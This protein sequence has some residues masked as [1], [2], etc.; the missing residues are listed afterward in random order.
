MPSYTPGLDYIIATLDALLVKLR[1][2][3]ETTDEALIGVSVGSPEGV[4]IGSPGDLR[5]AIPG[6][7]GAP[8]GLWQKQ[9]GELTVDGWVEISG[10]SGALSQHFVV[11]QA[12]DVSLTNA[13]VLTA[14]TNITIDLTVPGQVIINAVA[15]GG[16]T[17]LQT[18][19]TNQGAV[20]TTQAFSTRIQF[21][22]GFGWEFEDQTGN[23]VVTISSD[24]LA[25][26]FTAQG[27]NTAAG[28]GQAITLTGGTA[29]VATQAGG[30]I[31]LTGGTGN[32]TGTGGNLN[33]FAGPGGATG[34]GGQ[35]TILGGA[36]GATSGNGGA[37]VMQGGLP[38]DGNG[39]DVTIAGRNAATTTASNRD[40]GDV[41]ILGGLATLA[42]VGGNIA[43]VA[44]G[45]GATGTA[46]SLALTGGAA[47]TGS[48]ASG[49]VQ[50]Q[51][52]PSVAGATGSITLTTGNA[53]GGVAGDVVLRGG[54]GTTDGRVLV[55]PV[56]S[57]D[58]QM[59]ALVGNG[60]NSATAGLHSGSR[61]PNGVVSGNPGSIYMRNTGASGAA[62]INT[63]LADPGTV[64]SQISTTG[65]VT[66][67]L[68]ITNQSTTPTSQNFDTTIGLTGGAAWLFIDNTGSGLIAI[69][70]GA[71][72]GVNITGQQVTATGAG[73]D[74]NL[75]GGSATGLNQTGGDAILAGGAGNGSGLPG[76][77]RV[78]SAWALD[79]T[80]SPAALAAGNNNNYA[81]TNGTVTNTWRLSPDA[82]GS[83]ITGITGGQPGRKIEIF[84]L[85][86][87]ASITLTN[88]DTG[89]SSAVNC[90]L[91]PNSASITIPPLGAAVI[92]YDT[93]SSRWRT[94]A[95]ASGT[96]FVT[97]Q[98]AITNQGATPTTQSTDTRIQIGNTNSWQ[99]ED[100]GGVDVVVI[101]G[102][103]SAAAFTVQGGTTVAGAGQTAS[104]ATGAATAA[105]QA[106]GALSLS[107]GAG[108]TTGLGGAIT[109][110]SGQGGDTANGGA[111]TLT[112]G[113]GGPTSGTGGTA[114]L[115]G[116]PG[117]GVGANGGIVVVQG[118]TATDGNGGAATI[119][120]RNGVGTNRNGGAMTVAGGTA[121]GSG[122]GG[123]VN[124]FAGGGGSAGTPGAVTITGG[125]GGTVSGTAGA[126]TVQGGLPTDGNGGAVNIT[127]RAGVGTNRGGGAITLTAGNATGTGVGGDINK[128][129]G[130]SGTGR[131]GLE[132]SLGA[133]AL[134]SILTP[135]ALAAGN[136]NN[137]APANL[138]SANAL[139]LTPDATGSTITGIEFVT[140]QNGRVLV[141]ENISTT[142][143]ITLTNEDGLSTATNRF[144]LPGNASVTI[145]PNGSFQIWYDPTSGRWR[146]TTERSS[147]A[148][149]AG[150]PGNIYANL[151]GYVDSSDRNS[152]PGSGTIVT[153]IM[154]NATS[155]V[156]AT[157]TLVEGSFSF[158]GA[159]GSL[160]FTKN[161]NLD[162]IF[163]GGGTVLA[164]VRPASAGE[165]GAGRIGDTTQSGTTTGWFLSATS[166][167]AD[168]QT[169]Q[170]RRNFSTAQANWTANNVTS[171][172]TGASVRPLELGTWSCVA[173]TYDDTATANDPIFYVNGEVVANTENVTPTG[174]AGS[175][176]GN[177]LVIG[178]RTADDAT[179]NGQIGIVLY[180]DRILSQNEII[181]VYNDFGRRYGMG[182][183]GWLSTVER[184]QSVYIRAGL[185]S[186]ANT[187][188]NG[189]DI[190]LLAGNNS[191]ASSSP[192]AGD[193]VI[194]CGAITGNG[195]GRSGALTVL[196][197]AS[198][199]TGSLAG[200]AE[201]GCGVHGNG[202]T[203]GTCTV[204]AGDNSD[205]GDGGDCVVR[206]GDCITA[207]VGNDNGGNLGLRAGNTRNAGNAGNTFIAPG[208]VFNGTA[209]TTGDITISTQR[210]ALGPFA[211]TGGTNTDTGNISILT[212]GPGATADVTGNI[213]I[214]TGDVAATTSVNVGDISIT[215]G[216][217][218]NTTQT[219]ATAGNITLT[220]GANAGGS[221]SVA[222][223]ITLTAGAASGTGANTGTGGDISFTCG[224]MA[225]NSA[226]SRAGNLTGTAGS[227][228]GTNG[229][230]GNVSFT[231][232]AS[233]GTGT[234]GTASLTA[235]AGAAAAT[236]G[237]ATVA[238]GAGGGTSG[239][240]GAL[241]LNGGAGG[242]SGSGGA[243]TITAGAA[244]ATGAAGGTSTIQGGTAT[245]GNGGGVTIT[246]R[247]GVGTNRSGG[248]VSATAGNAT[249]TG[250]GGSVS[251]TAGSG[252][253]SGTAGTI[254]ITGGAG[255]SSSGAGGA[256][257][258]SGGTPIDGNGGAITLTAANGVGT[259]RAGG[260]MRSI[261]GN[262]VG[263][264][265]GGSAEVTSGNGGAQGNAGNVV[266]TSGNGG[267][268]SG[269]SGNILAN[270]GT[271]VSGV[272]GEFRYAQGS[273]GRTATSSYRA[274]NTQTFQTTN[275]TPFVVTIHTLTTNGRN[276][277]YRFK[278]R[279]QISTGADIISMTVDQTA[280]RSGGTVT[281][282]TAEATSTQNTAW[283]G[284]PPTIV[285]SASG[286]DVI[287]TITGIA[288]TTINWSAYW[289]KQEGGA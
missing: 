27:G 148:S 242:G 109:A 107:A 127:G 17:T 123:N 104:I 176:V 206:A 84:N 117:T 187:D 102:D 11:Y 140:G 39:G 30:S 238:A 126:V 62:Y 282:L 200:S 226:A 188:T 78:N 114:A 159:S 103:N 243:V 56:W 175:D 49:P 259:N 156:L 43:V 121:T 251:L 185:S 31:A 180:F 214:Q 170:L 212:T 217:A 239:T 247:A 235:G 163:A 250:T 195:T 192:D 38:V 98:A 89:N 236:G 147:S 90:F 94:D 65:A 57:G 20:P 23:D 68:A 199:G 1:L 106:G 135:A 197:G 267:G 233:T 76:M 108:N 3:D 255:G 171:P 157:A 149:T 16:G 136:N 274:D 260:A 146:S 264:G 137:Y 210:T 196:S 110:T 151:Q 37:A 275:A 158:N 70:D 124:M 91:L 46:G 279:G 93:V 115:A 29:T 269:D 75:A 67:Q 120:G 19:I 189:G 36:G 245:D 164:F 169:I 194:R 273:G 24:G 161:T 22:T 248:A 223:S 144:S 230:G 227:A 87:T 246:G 48:G 229:T 112:A 209:S 168:R 204:H 21:N 6:E 222:G 72:I 143:S 100:A 253:A 66:L 167:S 162:N 113:A 69:D 33:L 266:L 270:T 83:T 216:A 15:G 211:A 139:R 285:L 13:R 44:G 32:T 60:A 263:T 50:I 265:A 218:T 2:G 12:G 278:I 258:I 244:G 145:A 198:T 25:T 281:L 232:G 71:A 172:I 54:T 88:D 256:V 105:G 133:V 26:A 276:V 166:D 205:T 10:L 45:G 81:P 231:A 101:A 119:Q 184:G 35:A 82:A 18:A 268:T 202:N 280:Y 237:T 182:Q 41:S 261:A 155:G 5:I 73:Q 201:F 177:S 122:S 92:W 28:A 190:L 262:G 96:G 150:L 131:F 287:A 241:N 221:G 254:S 8:V 63:S 7:V 228:T 220:A 283:G 225:H 132:F 191:A 80:I 116:G 55:Q 234:A 249:G 213:T 193:I 125:A 118:G 134:N 42:G 203:A 47:G 74:V 179:Y 178:N 257:T 64:W 272:V 52:Q 208:G 59:L 58:G 286:N 130:T 97:L 61:D 186:A 252:G 95:A 138:H 4:V 154:G 86:T 215:G 183:S 153:D 142:A 271:V 289:D 53:T 174:V 14:G 141:I 152:Y 99:F 85:S 224:A 160:T 277:G 51:S 79:S 9:T 129:P 34:N 128:T 219:S 111:L 181:T 207:T 288:A 165:G 240:G 284:T 40:G 77:V 173:V